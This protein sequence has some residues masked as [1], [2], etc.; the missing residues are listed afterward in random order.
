MRILTSLGLLP[1]PVHLGFAAS[2][3]VKYNFTSDWRLFVG[4]AKAVQASSFDDNDWK[5]I[6]TPHAW[7]ED[8]AF[9]V[10]IAN[11][12]TGIAW[13][14]K[15]F[16]LPSSATGKKVFLEFEGIRHSGEFYLNGNWI[17]RIAARIDNSWNYHEVS[18]GSTYQWSDKNLYANYGGINKNVYLHVADRLYQTLPLYSHLGTTG[19]YVY[20]SKIDDAR[21]TSITAESQVWNEYNSS[22]LLG[23]RVE[24]SNASSKVIKSFNGAH[25]TLQPNETRIIAASSVLLDLNFWGWGWGWGYGYL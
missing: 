24:V 15:N 3:R 1:A 5:P 16:K 10:D 25:Y 6:T 22:K 12:S 8:E 21:T 19:V 11:L 20:P 14:R 7:N 18:T 9:L 4:D 23:Y 17:G 13:Y 2:S